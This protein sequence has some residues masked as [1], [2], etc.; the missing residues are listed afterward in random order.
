[1]ANLLERASAMCT[2]E[3]PVTARTDGDRST[4]IDSVSDAPAPTPVLNQ[5][6][7]VANYPLGAAIQLPQLER[8]PYPIFAIFREREPV[9]WLAALNMWY[10][11]RYEDVRAIILDTQRFTTASEDSLLLDTFGVHLLTA[12]GALH[13]HY[14]RAVQPYFSPGFVRA[15]FEQSIR[16][17]TAKLIEGFRPGGTI[18]IRAAF[19]RRLP[20]QAILIA[21]GLPLSAE[22]L[23]RQWYDSFQAALAN[24]ARD[25][26]I[27][28]Q[29]HR[30]VVAFHDLLENEMRTDKEQRDECLL[31][32]LIHASPDTRL[33]PD[34]IRRNLS[35]ILFGGISTVEALILNTL[36]ALFQ[37]PSTLSRLH[38]DSSLL[39]QVIDETIRWLSPVQ[40]ATRHVVN[41]CEFAGVP[42][43]SGATVNCMLGAANRDP[44]VFP[45]PDVFNIDRSNLRRHLGF[46]TGLHSCVGFNLAKTEARIAIEELL[47]RL[48]QFAVRFSE[49]EAPTGYE[50]RQPNMLTIE[51]HNGSA[52]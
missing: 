11:T 28:D 2:N 31:G 18:E 24:F 46:G 48:P 16:C 26:A 49:S 17:A 4:G 41:D 7:R 45:D 22:P 43:E 29:A 27:R 20:I 14:R 8:D 19:A 9:T 32:G 36:W 39:P 35:I 51:W 34:E 38:S 33:T 5:S 12:E 23:I 37:H 25:Q 1:M 52:T 21:C 44:H 13:D 47:T 3:H 50:F 30:N 15:H 42:F 40:S 10:V 6:A